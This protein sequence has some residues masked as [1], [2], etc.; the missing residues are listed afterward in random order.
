MNH[1]FEK[2]IN[3]TF[4]NIEF[5]KQAF[6]HSSF[7]YENSLPFNNERLEFL[8]DA[9]LEL[10][11][12]EYLY[13]EF[14]RI[15]EGNLTKIRASIVCESSLASVA[16]K[17]RLGNFLK[18]GKG[19]ELTGGR[20]RDSILSDAL[21]A[22]FGAIYLDGG[23]QC[24]QALVIS[25]LGSEMQSTASNLNFRDYKTTLQ[26]TIQ[27]TS[28]KP[29]TYSIVKESGPDH[30]K[31]FTAQVFHSNILLGTGNGKSKKEAEQSA[32]FAALQQFN[33]VVR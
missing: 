27:K 7:S 13:K 31:L 24:V 21:E 22:V 23:F 10:V 8:G 28:Q 18:L 16:R 5:L 15:S 30:N 6:V 2:V 32:A 14:T 12:S 17:L 3:Y 25:L 11:I 19:E 33:I 4:K 20:D 1:D 9:V 29:L 26:E